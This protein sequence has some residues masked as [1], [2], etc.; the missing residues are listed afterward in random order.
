MSMQDLSQA[1]LDEVVNDMTEASTPPEDPKYFPDMQ[2]E[3]RERTSIVGWYQN[4]LLPWIQNQRRKCTFIVGWYQNELLP[5]F[6]NQ[7]LMNLVGMLLIGGPIAIYIVLA[8][9]YIFLIVIVLFL[10]ICIKEFILNLS[11]LN[12][13]SMQFEPESGDM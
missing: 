2:E 8:G 12:L 7:N 3:N 6:Q 5:W 1:I 13:G 11:N 4:E 10:M 9:L